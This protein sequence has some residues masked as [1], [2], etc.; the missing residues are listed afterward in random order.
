[1][2]FMVFK[3]RTWLVSPGSVKNSSQLVFVCSWSLPQ[4]MFLLLQNVV[5]E[6]QPKDASDANAMLLLA[7]KGG[8]GE[9]FGTVACFCM[10]LGL[11]APKVYCFSCLG[12]G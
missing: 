12:L 9:S 2:A 4:F 10:N 1:M 3:Q 5:S 7:Q 11:F 8:L 6:M